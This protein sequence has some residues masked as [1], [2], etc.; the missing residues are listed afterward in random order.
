ML[1]ALLLT[2]IVSLTANA[3]MAQDCTELEMD[4]WYDDIRSALDSD[5]LADD[6]QERA[7]AFARRQLEALVEALEFHFDTAF[8]LVDVGHVKTVEVI[9]EVVMGELELLRE[10]TGMTDTEWA[11]LVLLFTETFDRQTL[12]DPEAAREA[13]AKLMDAVREHA[14]V[15]Q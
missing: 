7:D 15:E 4:A 12:A 10:S 9:G 8:E 14:G 2:A 13:A 11:E 6:A 3:A 5:A 1:R